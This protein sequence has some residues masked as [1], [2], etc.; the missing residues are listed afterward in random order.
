VTLIFVKIDSPVISVGRLHFLLRAAAI[1]FSREARLE[2][3]FHV[4]K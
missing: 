4:K 3:D 1:S 2:I